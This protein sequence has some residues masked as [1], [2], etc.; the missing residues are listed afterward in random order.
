MFLTSSEIIAVASGSRP[1]SFSSFRRR[2]KGQ[3]R[4]NQKK[5]GWWG[6]DKDIVS[7]QNLTPLVGLFAG[8]DYPV[9][10]GSQLG[11]CALRS[12]MSKS[13]PCVCL[14]EL[15]IFVGSNWPSLSSSIWLYY[16]YGFEPCLKLPKA[17]LK[18]CCISDVFFLSILTWNSTLRSRF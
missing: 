1:S 8:F 7:A 5:K 3:R 4:L 15:R 14:I 6:R 18:T 10:N 9:L 12:P 13:P 17:F 11:V 16:Q 2:E